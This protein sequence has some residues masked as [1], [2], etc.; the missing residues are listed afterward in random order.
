[1]HDTKLGTPVFYRFAVSILLACLL[2]FYLQYFLMRSW[3]FPA[4]A[5]DCSASYSIAQIKRGTTSIDIE[6]ATLAIPAQSPHVSY[7]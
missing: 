5:D 2:A 6:D 3:Y 4:D 7:Q 1:M